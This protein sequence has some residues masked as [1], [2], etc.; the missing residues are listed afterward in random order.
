[1]RTRPEIVAC[2][3]DEPIVWVRRDCSR[4]AAI[5]SGA[6]ECC[7]KPRRF[8]ARKR[9]LREATKELDCPVYP[10]EID[11]DGEPPEDCRCW[12]IEE[13]WFFQC[14][15]DAPGAFSVWRVEERPRRF[16]WRLQR[17][18]GKVLYRRRS[19][20]ARQAVLW[21]GKLG[22]RATRLDRWLGCGCVVFLGDEQIRLNVGAM[23]YCHIC[24]MT[25]LHRVYR[26]PAEP[27]KPFGRDRAGERRICM[28][29]GHVD[30]EF[31]S[32]VAA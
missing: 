10:H 17:L 13:G 5:R 6:H 28:A 18:S 16:W 4:L 9:Y 30:R 29:D 8:W 25:T 12:Q 2:S 21:G 32:E 15:A 31:P 14:E 22:R 7:A 3:E 11:E 19:F 26:W 1:M 24:Q 20:E 23:Q 27:D